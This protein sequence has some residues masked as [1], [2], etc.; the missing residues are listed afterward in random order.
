[1]DGINV[2]YV[3]IIVKILELRGN[4][5]INDLKVVIGFNSIIFINN[6]VIDV[7][8]LGGMYVNRIRII[9]ID[10]GVG[11]NFDVFIVFKNSKLE[12]IVDGKIKVNKV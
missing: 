4:V 6:I 3:E 1:M 7:K 12:I 8:E 2:N 9:S 10:K 11:V 5:V